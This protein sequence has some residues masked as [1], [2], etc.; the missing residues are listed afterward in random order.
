VGDAVV[1]ALMHSERESTEQFERK[2]W[3]VTP[4]LQSIRGSRRVLLG[5]ALLLSL[6]AAVG[7]GFARFGYALLLPPMQQSLGWT[8]AQAGVVNSANAL[9]YLCG[10]LAVGPCVAR[11]SAPRVV[12]L[13]LLAVSLSLIASGWFTAYWLLLVA[14]IVAGVGAGLMFI[15]GVAVVLELDASHHSDLPVGVYYAGPGIGIAISGLVV[16]WLLGVLEWEWRTVWVALG[17][18]GLLSQ[19]LI[20]P[21]LRRAKRTRRLNASATA[22]QRQVVLRDYL[23][24]WPGLLAYA[25]FGLGYIGYMTFVVAFLRAQNVAPIIIQ[26]FWVLLGVC[27]ALCGFT[28]RP[29]LRRLAPRY[30]L[31]CILLALSFGAGLPVLVSEPWSFALSAVLFGSSF[32]AVVTAITMQVRQ[33]LPIE[34]WTTVMGNATALFALGQLLGPTLTGMIADTRGGLSLGLRGSAALLGLAAMI[35]LIKP[36]A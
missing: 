13:S 19:V 36:R 5:S 23:R 6:G 18:L 34:R 22:P 28:W 35:A 26:S 10:A 9:G 20:E 8:Y 16:P 4:S 29:V 7:Q 25:L 27:A 12:R 17:A 31:G 24:L 1:S 11:W 15:G 30:A 2:S 3:V 21:P 14:R 32:L 33:M